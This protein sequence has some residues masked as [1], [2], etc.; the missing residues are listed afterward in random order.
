MAKV[1]TR[2]PTLHPT[3][4]SAAQMDVANTR[5]GAQELIEAARRPD[6]ESPLPIRRVRFS[7]SNAQR[8][9]QGRGR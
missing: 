7:L 5:M 3:S 4:I 1:A 6:D 8:G 9:G 2:V